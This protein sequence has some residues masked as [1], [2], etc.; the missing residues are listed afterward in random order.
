MTKRNLADT[1]RVTSPCSQNWDSMKGNDRVRFCEHCDLSVNNL[2]EMTRKAALR[3]A[4]Q[5]K[6]GICVRYIKNPRT[7]APV[8]SDKLYQIAR[9]VGVAASVLSTSLAVSIVVYA[10]DGASFTKLLNEKNETSDVSQN[11]SVKSKETKTAVVSGIV[12][13]PNGAVIPA[14]NVSLIDEN[15]NQ[16]QNTLSNEEGVYKFKEVADG[17]YKIKVES[18]NFKN[19]EITGIKIKNG[20]DFEHNVSL[21]I[22]DLNVA[23]GGAMFVDYEQPLLRSVSENE[24]DEVKSL[25]AKGANVNA[26]DKN[27]SGITSLFVAVEEGNT[28]MVG[29]LLDFGAKVNARDDEKRTPL[30]SLDDDAKPEL[31]NL[32]ISYGAKINA[33]DKERNSALILS[34]NSVNAT[35]LQYLL[36][37]GAKLNAQNNDGQTALMNAAED[38][39]LENVKILLAAGADVNLKNSDGETAW[40]LTSDDEIKKLLEIYGS[41]VQAEIHP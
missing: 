10:Q 38:D 30:M 18:L 21:E 6:G 33:V 34:A 35:V 22:G 20:S 1:F 19:A 3:L 15:N 39:N 12:T 9:R 16:N 24:I 17:D 29:I 4:R 41:S 8:F 7:D 36:N 25:L 27:Y 26:K 28:K 5:S 37:H 23:V 13:D 14:A 32:L 2:S 11:K 31:V 40:S